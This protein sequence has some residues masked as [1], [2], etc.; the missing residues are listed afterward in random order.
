LRPRI[1]QR[2]AV[3]PRLRPELVLGR[4]ARVLAPP[5]DDGP[6]F[7]GQVPD[8]R[9]A[10][11]LPGLRRDVPVQGGHADEPGQALRG[12]VAAG[13][14]SRN[15]MPN[16][17]ASSPLCALVMVI[18]ALPASAG[19]AASSSPS[20]YAAVA[21]EVRATLDPRWI[22]ART[23]TATPAAA[24]SRRPSCPPTSPASPAASPR[25]PTA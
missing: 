4:G 17:R 14:L 23:S 1:H 11:E 18:A 25:S 20:P 8:Q 13:A 2:P 6:P 21:A 7:A 24:G 16:L 3:L 9:P 22:P 10:V 12:L 19:G 15:V 5:G